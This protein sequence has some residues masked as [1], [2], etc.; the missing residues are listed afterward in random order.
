[1]W[2]VSVLPFARE[3]QTDAGSIWGVLDGVKL[4]GP[5]TLHKEEGSVKEIRTHFSL[6]RY[7]CI[8]HNSVLYKEGR[9][10]MSDGDKRHVANAAERDLKAGA[11]PHPSFQ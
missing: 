9:S 4:L 5:V 10:C 11:R 6:Y 2:Y 1:M 7:I 8:H 3:R